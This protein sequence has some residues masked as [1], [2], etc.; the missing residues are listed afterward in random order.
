MPSV[1]LIDDNAMFLRY[2]R[3]FLEQGVGLKVVGTA[4]RGAEGLEQAK[5]LQP[6]LILLDLKMQEES[7]L[8]LL[9]A[10]QDAV[11]HA[12]VVALTS[13]DAPAY[14]EVVRNLGGASLIS[15][16]EMGTHLPAEIARLFGRD[17][18][19]REHQRLVEER[20]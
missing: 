13:L 18:V 15:K 20:S 6:D 1:L 5:Q 4:Q 2:T 7:G 11:P 12:R 8:D 9:P 19:A 17:D 14:R 10:L 16:I 3:R